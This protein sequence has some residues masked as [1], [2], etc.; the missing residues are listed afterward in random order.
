[1]NDEFIWF[2]RA[3]RFSRLK[4]TAANSLTNGTLNEASVGFKATEVGIGHSN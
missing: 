2:H 4:D 3:R 1:M